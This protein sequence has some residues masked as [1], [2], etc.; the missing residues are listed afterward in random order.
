MSPRSM[1]AIRPAKAASAPS[2]SRRSPPLGGDERR[3]RDLV[4]RSAQ[5]PVG[6]Q[7]L[8]ERDVEVDGSGRSRD[9]PSPR[10]ARQ[11]SARARR[12]AGSPS[13]QRQLGEPLGMPA[14]DAVL[15][16][17]LRRAAVPQLGRPVGGEDD[18][19][20]A[21]QYDASTTAGSKLRRPP[22]RR[23]R[24]T[25]TGRRGG[26]R[27]A[28]REEPGR[29]LVEQH[30]DA[31]PGCAR[32]AS[33]SGVDREPGHTTASRTPGRDQ[34]RRRRRAARGV[35]HRRLTP[36]PPG[37]RAPTITARSFIRDSSHS[38]G[39]VRVGDDPA[40]GEQRGPRAGRRCRSAGRP[41]LAVA[42]RAEPADR[43]RVPAAIEALVLLDHRQ[44][45]V[46]RLRRRR[47]GSGGGD[48]PAPGGRAPRAG[49]R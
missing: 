48:R 34:L 21:R 46:A 3:R 8:A 44:R 10:R 7:R 19:R 36:R 33:A 5:R 41:Q 25:A 32:S 16:D 42:V 20:H 6:Q 22:S 9:A 4:G 45:D 2:S 27:Q 40:A 39:R 37:S 18:E 12:V 43:A 29:P 13:K 35:A 38:R 11:P 1:P 47:P 15:V 31:E 49:C 14:E 17:G 28:E 23:S 30:A 26:P 24:A